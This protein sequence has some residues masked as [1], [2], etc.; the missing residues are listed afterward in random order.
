M[1]SPRSL[2]GGHRGPG[3][4]QAVPIGYSTRNR[5]SQQNELR[6]TRPYELKNPSSGD[7]FTVAAKGSASHGKGQRPKHQQPSDCDRGGGNAEEQPENTRLNQKCGDSH[8]SAAVL[9][10]SRGQAFDL[11]AGSRVGHN[12]SYS[13][14]AKACISRDREV[15]L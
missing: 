8:I 2:S 11:R 9:R 4:V 1:G 13:C 3:A 5:S 7:C 10:R 15:E 14:G 12:G 6:A